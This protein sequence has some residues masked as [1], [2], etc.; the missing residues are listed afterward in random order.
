LSYT[1]AKPTSLEYSAE[2]TDSAEKNATSNTG[3]QDQAFDYLSAEA[4]NAEAQAPTPTNKD[5]GS[6]IQIQQ[7]SSNETSSVEVSTHPTPLASG[8]NTDADLF[9]SVE[10]TD[11][12][13]DSAEANNG[14]ET[15][16]EVGGATPSGSGEVGQ[17]T[18][19]SVGSDEIDKT[20]P[21]SVGGSGEVQ[22][23]SSSVD[24]G[25]MLGAT[26]PSSAESAEIG[27]TTPSSAG[28]GETTDSPKSAEAS[29]E[30]ASVTEQT[31][32]LNAGLS[33]LMPQLTAAN[34]LAY[35]TLDDC[36]HQHRYMCSSPPIAYLSTG[37]S[38]LTGHPSTDNKLLSMYV[39]QVYLRAE[40]RSCI[41]KRPF[42]G[43]F[44]LGKYVLKL[45]CTRV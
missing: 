44:F 19:S 42:P 41:V 10:V 5:K 37:K 2:I 4:L 33:F 15:S 38:Q 6:K 30:L 9:G 26:T 24:S 22:T 17:T 31:P 8:A 36:Q 21:T 20:T 29:N 18:P 12:P 23:N 3:T 39:L 45:T 35:M 43:T 1:T 13:P 34:T 11:A 7:D 28:S 32:N 25:E 14:T 40:P 27:Q 16:S